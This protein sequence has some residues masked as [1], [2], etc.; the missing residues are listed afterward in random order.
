M[1]HRNAFHTF[2]FL[3]DYPFTPKR[4]HNPNFLSATVSFL[5]GE[6]NLFCFD[7][8]LHI[9]ISTMPA[10]TRTPSLI[11]LVSLHTIR[12]SVRTCWC[13]G[14]P[15]RAL[16]SL[17]GRKSLLEH[18]SGLS[19][20][21]KTIVCSHAMLTVVCYVWLILYPQGY[22]SLIWFAFENIRSLINAKS[23]LSLKQK[24]YKCS[25]SPLLLLKQS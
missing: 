9:N 18:I 6:Y 22:I 5:C 25:S 7:A 12:P 2:Y 4:S 21:W 19:S 3:R 14:L 1:L 23:L 8:S 13:L 10:P 11:C 15:P 24:E 17:P 16:C 20:F